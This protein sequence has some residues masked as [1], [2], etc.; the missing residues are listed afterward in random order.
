[1]SSKAAAGGRKGGRKA[2]GGAQEE[3]DAGG[4]KP[5]ISASKRAGLKFP[6]KRTEHAIRTNFGGRVSGLSGVYL[7]A[8]LEYLAAEVIELASTSAK[9]NKRKRITC[10]DLKLVIG[11]DS[12]LEK[13]LS[14][15]RIY[16]GGVLPHIHRTLLSPAA[17]Q[18]LETEEAEA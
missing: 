1:M 9:Q 15:V 13:T 6:V 16:G 5:S 10:R 2:K 17:A 18:N 3:D 8:T 7:A 12:D 14:R 11:N 4:K